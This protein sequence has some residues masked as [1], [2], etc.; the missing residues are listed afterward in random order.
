MK[1]LS[2]F[3]SAIDGLNQAVAGL[4]RWLVLVMLGLGVWNVIG[5][6]LGL[7][8]GRNLS[9]NSLIEA[10]WYAFS[11]LFLLGAG[12]TLQRNGH[13]RVD[14]LQARLPPQRRARLEVVGTFLFLIPYCLV[15]IAAAWGSVAFSWQLGELSPDP[16][17]LPRFPIKAMIPLGFLLLLLQ[18]LA[19]VA[20]TLPADRSEKGAPGGRGRDAG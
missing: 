2:R 16:G 15:M 5:R 14:V 8:V 18:G 1:P 20:A 4:C 9:S 7:L 12:Y 17:G 6:Y 10:Q 19:E 11:V 13:V 3:H